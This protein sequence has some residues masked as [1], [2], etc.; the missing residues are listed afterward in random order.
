MQL[1]TVF[2]ELR[3]ARDCDPQVLQ[4]LLI[5]FLMMCVPRHY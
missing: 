3:G 4:Q 2:Q 1:H 5:G